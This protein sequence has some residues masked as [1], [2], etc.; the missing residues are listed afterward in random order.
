MNAVRGLAAGSCGG[1]LEGAV[2]STRT[3]ADRF[4]QGSRASAAGRGEGGAAFCDI[5]RDASG[6]QAG[7]GVLSLLEHAL[8]AFEV[9]RPAAGDEPTGPAD[10]GAGEEQRRAEASLDLSGAC[11]YHVTGSNT[12]EGDL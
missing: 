4:W 9:L 5:P 11:R 8:C 3:G 1:V 12:T 7:G 10:V 2:E 6:A